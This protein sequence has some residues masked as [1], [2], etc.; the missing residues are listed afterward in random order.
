MEFLVK[1]VDGVL[2][3]AD[4]DS[5]DKISSLGLDTIGKCHVSKKRNYKNLQ[6]FHV[7]IEEA[8]S[9]Q[10]HY[11][12]IEWFRHWLIMKAGYCDTHV[13]PNGVVMFKPKSISYENMEEE[14]FKIVFKKCVNTFIDWAKIKMTD[15][16]F[17][18]I[19]DFE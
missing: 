16:D 17:W 7:F 11:N 1:K 2:V 6:R 13:A 5:K 19:V 4:Q 18:R 12:D 8:F 3:G 10:T 9:M 14:E 15:N